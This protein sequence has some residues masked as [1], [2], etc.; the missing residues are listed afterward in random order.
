MHPTAVNNMSYEQTDADESESQVVRL[1]IIHAWRGDMGCKKAE[2][3][4][5]KI[6]KVE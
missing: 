2:I 4:R 5:N 6:L 1:V 3:G